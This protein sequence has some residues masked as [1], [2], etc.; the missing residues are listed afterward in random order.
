MEKIQKKGGWLMKKFVQRFGGW[1]AAFALI[2]T[3]ITANSTCVW[4]SYQ[5]E[6][7]ERVKRLRRF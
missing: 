7:P 2:V 4:A 1:I 6:I 5:P 3:T